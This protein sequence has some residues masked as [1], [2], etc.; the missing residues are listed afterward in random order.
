MI[1]ELNIPSIDVIKNETERIHAF[2]VKAD[3]KKFFS[4]IPDAIKEAIQ[5]NRHFA[6]ISGE[7]D[8]LEINPDHEDTIDTLKHLETK[9]FK[10][11]IW[12]YDNT[13]RLRGMIK[14]IKLEW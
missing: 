5:N 2:K 3:I 10:I 8:N 12:L 11:E 6:I 1:V 9:G 13:S 4:K 7:L 14:N